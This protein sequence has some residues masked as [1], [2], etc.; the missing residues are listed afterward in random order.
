MHSIGEIVA[1]ILTDEESAKRFFG[2]EQRR[3]PKRGW[4]GEET[5]EEEAERIARGVSR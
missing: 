5:I 2:I 3:A 1:Q 4:E